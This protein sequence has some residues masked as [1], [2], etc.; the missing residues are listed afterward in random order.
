MTVCKDPAMLENLFDQ[1]IVI[2]KPPASTME[3]TQPCDARHSYWSKDSAEEDSHCD[4]VGK[5]WMRNS[6]GNICNKEH[7]D[8][9][10]ALPVYQK[11]LFTNGLLRVQLALQNSMR[12]KLITDS[13]EEVGIHPLSA[14]RILQICKIPK[15]TA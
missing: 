13:F 4:L 11:K 2:G 5:D 8:K 6:L 15:S 14:I 3:I 9:Y 1:N 12:P 7:E 10:G